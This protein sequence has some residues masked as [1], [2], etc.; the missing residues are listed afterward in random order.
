MHALCMQEDLDAQQGGQME[1][2]EKA[3]QAANDAGD[4]AAAAAAARAADDEEEEDVVNSSRQEV[5]WVSVPW[6]GCHQLL[7]CSVLHAMVRVVNILISPF[8]RSG[9][10]NETW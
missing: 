8:S 9:A 1:A 6:R 5:S 4:A 2:A 3:E 10:F 7:T